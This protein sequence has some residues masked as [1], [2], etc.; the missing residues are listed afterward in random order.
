MDAGGAGRNFKIMRKYLAGVIVYPFF[1]VLTPVASLY[2]GNIDKFPAEVMVV[3]LIACCLITAMVWGAL[4]LLTK[5]AQK[6]ALM[7]ALLSVVTFASGLL[8]SQLALLLVRMQLV[9]TAQ[10]VPLLFQRAGLLVWAFILLVIGAGLCYLIW[11]AKL[12]MRTVTQLFNVIGLALL[13]NSGVTWWLSRDRNVQAYARA[14]RA[15][16]QAETFGTEQV[17]TPRYDLYYIIVDGYTNSHILESIY[18]M[19]NTDFLEALR[20]RGF[21]VAEEA[22]ANYPQTALSLASSMNMMYLDEQIRRFADNREKEQNRSPLYFMLNENRV[23]HYLKGQGYMLVT[24]MS[25]SAFTELQAVDRRLASPWT[26]TM[27]SNEL[28]NQTPLPALTLDLQYHLHRQRVL[29]QFDHLAD[30]AAIESPTFLFAHILVPHP[31]FVFGAQGEPIRPDRA[32]IF[33]DGSHYMEVSGQNRAEYVA[34][35]RDQ[36]R[37]VNTQV[38][39]AIDAILAQSPAPPIIILQ[40][41]HGPGSQ[42]DW[43]SSEQSNLEER[44]SILNAFFFPD[45]DYTLLYDT[46]TPVNTFRVILRQYFGADLPLLEARMYYAP[47]DTPYDFVDVT[48][49]ID[50]EP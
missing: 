2:F 28:L 34:G 31:P 13:F 38:L 46:I 4:F 11:R 22:H 5:D 24:F 36:V 50:Q 41:D 47:W 42:L 8:K 17:V 49:Q 18:Q 14:W 32:L 15:D 45:Q 48:A 37:F 9:Q 33:H 43:S 19:D 10:L 6:S 21:F 1:F 3:P 12:N 39:S 25:G 16:L 20:Q 40:G 26:L 29:Y 35:Y 7:V 30:V 27:F 44:F 23:F